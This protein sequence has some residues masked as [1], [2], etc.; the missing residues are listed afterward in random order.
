MRIIPLVCLIAATFFAGCAYE[1]V[2]VQKNSNPLPL[3]HSIG[4]DGSYSFILRDRLGA[5]HRQIVTPEV[6]ERYGVGDYFN[7]LQSGPA[8][9]EV[10]D[11]KTLRTAMQP[12]AVTTPRVARMRKTVKSTRVATTGKHKAKKH[13]VRRNKRHAP[14]SKVAHVQPAPRITMAQPILLA[15]AACCR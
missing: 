8:G 13:L 9:T 2:I 15:S 7:D 4:V 11:G 5:V 14:V 3:Y 12:V 1:G 10:V 6:F